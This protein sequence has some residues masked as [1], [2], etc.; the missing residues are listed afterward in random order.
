MKSNIEDYL[1][2]KDDGITHINIYTKGRTGLGR[3]LTNM[4]DIPV[5]TDHG[6]FKSMEGYWHYLKIKLI[7][8]NFDPKN[9]QNLTCYE[10]KKLNKRIMNTDENL[11]GLVSEVITSNDFR[12]KILVALTGKINSSSK[13]KELFIK[14]DL[15]FEHY[16]Y[17]GSIDNPKVH[18]LPQYNWITDYLNK[19]ILT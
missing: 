18:N 5:T 16:Y 15:P 7:H 12:S 11:S 14:N 4:N 6:V 19:L 13:M 9:Y 2:P 3:F 10:A 8:E 1:H 17:Y